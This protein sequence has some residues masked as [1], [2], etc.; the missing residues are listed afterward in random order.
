MDIKLNGF[1]VELDV[2][3]HFNRYRLVTLSSQFYRSK[4]VKEY[5][6]Y[7]NQ[8][9][10]DCQARAAFGKYWRT[11]SADR[12]FGPSEPYGQLTGTCSSR[13]KQRAFCDYLRD[14]AAEIIGC[15]LIRI[16]VFD[17]VD[18]VRIGSILHEQKKDLYD[19]LAD[20]VRTK[21]AY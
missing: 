14:V 4:S 13:W 2:E 16:S 10:E 5:R 6:Y 9:E 1:V 7:C 17:S 19:R 3:Q 11:D 18:G 15:Q 8:F 21:R 12:Q 20:F